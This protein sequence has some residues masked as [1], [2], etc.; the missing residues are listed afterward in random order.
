MLTGYLDSSKKL[1]A[2]YKQLGENALVQVP[3]DK[4]FYQPN[5]DSNSIAIIMQHLSGNMLSRWTDFLNS[6]GEKEWRNRDGEFMAG[7][8]TRQDLMQAWERGWQ[9]LF[10]ALNGLSDE[11]LQAIVYIRGEA[12][13]VLEAINRQLAH[14]AYHVGQILYVCKMLAG[15]PWKSL[16]IPKNQSQEYNREKFGTSQ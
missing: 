6:D 15:Q 9:C 13:T 12:H 10:E 1:F 3:E 2:Y 5:E 16:S 4:L 7:I 8:D 11:D 14:Y